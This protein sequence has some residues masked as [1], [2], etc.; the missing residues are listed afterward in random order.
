MQ[1]HDVPHG[2]AAALDLDCLFAGAAAAA[3]S[4]IHGLSF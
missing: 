4:Q 3:L 2:T 1:T